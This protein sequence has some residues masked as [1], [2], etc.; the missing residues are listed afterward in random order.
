MNEA[1]GMSAAEPEG[2]GG[3]EGA[4]GSAGA[5][6]AEGTGRPGGR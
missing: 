4:A 2:A 3:A 1:G 6:G 5:E